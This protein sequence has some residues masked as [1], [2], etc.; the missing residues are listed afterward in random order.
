MATFNGEAYIHEQIMSILP[1]LEEGDELIISDDGS[2]DDTLSI[3]EKIKDNRIII[4][5]GPCL[6]LIKNF[7]NALSNARGDY[8]F[9]SDQDDIW[10]ENKVAEICKVFSQ[11]NYDLIVTDCQ[12][13]DDNLNVL[14][15]SFFRW[16]NSGKGVLKNLYKNTYLGCCMIFRREILRR[17]LPFPK[18]IPM[19]DWWLGLTANLLGKTYFLDMP[20]V[21]YRRHDNNVS[22]TSTGKSMSLRKILFT[23]WHLVLALSKV[24]K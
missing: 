11:N 14:I 19:H 24:K 20:L 15:P 13:I 22:P 9:L 10:A 18:D 1:Q 23:R 4:L 7:E 17:C 12:V 5:E 2:V 3:I 8:I 6:G 21:K 16:R